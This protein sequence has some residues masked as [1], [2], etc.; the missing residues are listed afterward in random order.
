VEVFGHFGPGKVSRVGR[1]VVS[2]NETNFS[3]NLKTRPQKVTL[4][5]NNQILCENKTV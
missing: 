4:D 1:V 5:E 2:G 3:L